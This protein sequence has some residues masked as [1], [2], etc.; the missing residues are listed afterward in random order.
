MDDVNCR[1]YNG[2]IVYNIKSEPP[3]MLNTSSHFEDL[4]NAPFAAF[5]EFLPL[6]SFFKMRLLSKSLRGRL[7][8][9]S[10]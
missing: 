8:E 1:N 3:P 9:G 4:T 2:S 7:I 6:S 5:V 10:K